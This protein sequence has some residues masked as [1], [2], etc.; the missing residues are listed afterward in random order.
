MTKDK[1]LEMCFEMDDEPDPERCPP[2]LEDFPADVQK[3][4]L[5]YGML[6]DRIAAD[7]GYLG[8]DLTSLPVLM[9]IYE[10]EYKDLFIQTILLLDQKMIEKSAAAMKRERDKLKQK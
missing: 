8:K 7:I 5:V 6:G 4:I 3:G 9:D 10:I 1:Y 2:D